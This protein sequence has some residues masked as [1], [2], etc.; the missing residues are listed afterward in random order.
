MKSQQGRPTALQKEWLEYFRSEG[1]AS[2]VC[3]GFKAAQECLIEYIEGKITGKE[4][5]IWR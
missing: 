2:F 4:N 3:M 1:Y 5:M